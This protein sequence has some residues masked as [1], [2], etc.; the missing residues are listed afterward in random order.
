[1]ATFTVDSINDTFAVATPGTNELRS[2]I[3]Q[4][5]ASPGADIIEFDPNLSGQT[6]AL[7][8]GELTITDELIIDGDI[9]N[10]GSPD[11]TID[12]NLQTRVFNIND[13]DSAT[14]SSTIL[15]GLI[16]ENGMAQGNISGFGGPGGNILTFENLTVTGSIIRGGDAGYGGGIFVFENDLT[17]SGST[18]C[19]GQK[20]DY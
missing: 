14:N 8:L 10:D 20:I 16:I 3:L 7:A 4:A 11:V 5:N 17:I 1:M 13:G 19:T 9:D 2:L 15:D 12:A 18:L 6:I